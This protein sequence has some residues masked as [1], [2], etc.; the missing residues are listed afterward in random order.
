MT[1]GVY[2]AA[3]GMLINLFRHRTV[4]HNLAN[5]QTV[6]YKA[7]HVVSGEFAPF[8]IQ[9]RTGEAAG[10]PIGTVGAGTESEVVLTDF[11]DGS[12]RLTD[13]PFDLALTGAGFFQTQTPDGV[14]YTRDGRFQR[15]AQNRLVTATGH[16][17]LGPNGPI[18]LP[19][20][21]M[22]VTR[23]GE[24]FVDGEFIDQLAIVRF[25]DTG[26]LVKDGNT[27][28]VNDGAV[29]ELVPTGEVQ[30]HQGYLEASNVDVTRETIEMMSA[31]RAY[32]F[33]QRLIQFQ[34]RINE[35]A[36]NQLGR[37]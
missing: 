26:Q 24:I 20:G 2:T 18:V 12:L 9:Q 10:E 14:R 36:V 35:Q 16:L 8:L 6:G 1:R 4:T 11:G 30:V 21:Q 33:S 7:D 37:V 28:F 13:R 31:L 22:A 19:A 29:A 3:T 23:Q 17:V 32:Q 15:D 34:D 27:S 25:D 5:L